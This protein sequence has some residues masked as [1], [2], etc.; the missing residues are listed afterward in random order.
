M[1]I[2]SYVVVV[3]VVMKKRSALLKRALSVCVCERLLLTARHKS[4]YSILMQALK[5]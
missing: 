5:G 2:K 1:P 3:V 4:G